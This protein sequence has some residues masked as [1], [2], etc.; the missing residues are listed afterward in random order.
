MEIQN[1]KRFPSGKEEMNTW[2]QMPVGAS[3]G[4]CRYLV[5]LHKNGNSQKYCV[6]IKRGAGFLAGD[7]KFAFS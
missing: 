4:L 3:Q 5:V 2:C 7:L 6:K 1:A